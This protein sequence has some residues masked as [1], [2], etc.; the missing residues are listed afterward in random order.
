MDYLRLT[1]RK[2]RQVE[3]VEA[4]AKHQGLFREASVTE[5]ALYNEVL[6]LKLPEV[7]PSLAGPKRPQDRVLLENAPDAVHST[8]QE[9]R[10]SGAEPQ[11]VEIEIEESEPATLE[12]GDIVVAAITSCTNTSNPAVMVAAGLLAKNAI[13]KGLSVKPWVKTSLA[14][15]SQVVTEYLERSGLLES[16]EAL[17]FSI[18]GYGCTTC[19]GNSGPLPEPVANGIKS[20]DLIVS[21]VL[22]GNRNFEGRVHAAVKMNYLASPPLVVAF[23]LAGTMDVDLSNEP[24]GIDAKGKDVFLVDI[25]PTTAD[26]NEITDRVV[27]DELF[28]SKYVDVFKGDK[29][30]AKIPVVQSMSVCVA[31][32]IHLHSQSAIF[33]CDEKKSVARA[34]RYSWCSSV[35]SPRRQCYHRPHFTGGC[36]IMPNSPA[37]EYLIGE[38]VP[39]IDFNSYGSRRGNHEVMVRGTFANLRL[40]NQLAPGTEGGWTKHMPSGNIMTIYD[41]SVRYRHE[42]T[43]LIVIGGSEYGAGSS[44]DLGGERTSVAW[45]ESRHC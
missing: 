27:T 39:V 43:P 8:I 4:Y 18:V 7:K 31:S 15:G 16:L 21:S 1:G 35:G 5:Q 11:S 45:C 9:M 38:G 20:A 33:R 29:N 36:A 23:A 24:L 19:I 17:G 34:Q 12:D 6:E 22:S 3:L 14:P 26:V 41:A 40:R 13:S 42:K 44:R 30:W 10:G 37:G 32:I 25:W 28:L 2:E